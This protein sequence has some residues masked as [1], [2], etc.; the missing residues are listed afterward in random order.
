MSI[1]ARD[2]C[3]AWC[4]AAR[5]ACGAVRRGAAWRGVR[6]GAGCDSL[7][8]GARLA[9]ARWAGRATNCA[10]ANSAPAH[11]LKQ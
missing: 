7:A 6:A 11:K 10:H 2:A 8:G 1:V 4:G 3:A 9:A 5:R